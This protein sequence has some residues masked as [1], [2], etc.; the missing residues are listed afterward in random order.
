MSKFK[1]MNDL[2]LYYSDTDSIY[3]DKPLNSVYIGSELGKLKLEHIFYDAIFL[4]PK[5][6]GGITSSYEYV[7]VKGL[8]NPVSFN[9]LKPLL[10]KDA[11]LKINPEKWY[12][13]ISE[14]NIKILP[15]I[16]TL[17][18]NNQKRSLIYDNTNK[19]VDTSP[20]ILNNGN[21]E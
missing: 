14:G 9:Q 15:E 18:I 5:V 10:I 17:M 21:I 16:Y 4:A 2:T 11:N 13:N 19:F 7:K 1:T 6:Y 8:K 20:I 3:I 12:R